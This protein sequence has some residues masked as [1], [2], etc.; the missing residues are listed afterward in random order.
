MYLFEEFAKLLNNDFAFIL[1]IFLLGFV[2]IN[3]RDRRKKYFLYI[4]GIIVLTF[5]LK[6]IFFEQRVCS[7]SLIE[8]PKNSS[9]PSGHALVSFSAA[10]F[11]YKD[12]DSFLIVSLFAFVVSLSRLYLG[13]HQLVDIAAGFGFS[14]FYFSLWWKSRRI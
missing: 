10:L 12:R 6:S 13:V 5:V 7:L 4:I 9:F 14:F 3:S 1:F 8:C 11:F 2:F